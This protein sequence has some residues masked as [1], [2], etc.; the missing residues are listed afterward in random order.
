MS[1]PKNLVD[2]FNSRIR[3]N[4]IVAS[5]IILG[6]IVVGL[7]TFTG[8][9]KNLLDLIITDTRPDVN[10][11]WQAE[12][13][14]SWSNKKYS[15]TFNFNGD[16]DEVYGSASFLGTK[17]GILDG[18]VKKDKLRFI[19]TTAE[20]SGSQSASE[21]TH[22]YQGTISNDKISFIMQTRG[23]S[24]AKIPIEFVARKVTVNAN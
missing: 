14:Y 2:K 5:L 11:T 8:A 19:T 15:E 3:S 9:A 10:G 1:E 24:S 23:S 20:V 12:I 22:D 21:V 13:T 17:R 18:K 16:G 4:P 6:A 7:S